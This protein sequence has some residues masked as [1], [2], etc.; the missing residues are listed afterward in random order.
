MQRDNN[1]TTCLDGYSQ[2]YHNYEAIAD[3][4]RLPDE[5]RERLREENQRLLAYIRL[6]HEIR[7]W[8]QILRQGVDLGEID[9]RTLRSYQQ[10]VNMP[11]EAAKRPTV[12]AA[13][14]TGE[15]KAA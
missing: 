10:A 11:P 15:N 13:D 12:A 8:W 1:L 4:R 5:I 6:L 3:D 2:R 9:R 14:L 7:D